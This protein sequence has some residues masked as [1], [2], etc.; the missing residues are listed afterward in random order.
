MHLLR[1]IE[2]QM[3]VVGWLTLERHLM[4]TARAVLRML[5]GSNSPCRHTH[6]Y[7]YR[8]LRT[9]TPPKMLLEAD[10]GRSGRN[11]VG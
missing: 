6:A 10:H 7:R 11:Q 9:V 1:S 3:A 5:T 4:A 2:K 8:S